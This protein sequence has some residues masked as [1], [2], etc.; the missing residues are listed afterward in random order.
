MYE[1]VVKKQSWRT[2]QTGKIN[3]KMKKKQGKKMNFLDDL[4]ICDRIKSASFVMELYGMVRVII[5][6]FKSLI[7]AALH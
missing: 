6:N 4:R 2:V 5:I 7:V 1:L 3:Q